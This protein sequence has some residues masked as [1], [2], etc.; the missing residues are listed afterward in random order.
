MKLTVFFACCSLLALSNYA[1]AQCKKSVFLEVA[2][3]G[4]L[5]SMNYEQHF[6]KKTNVDLMWRVGLSLA[7]IDK[8]NGTGIV[9]P[10]MVNGLVGKNAHK[11]EVGLGQGVTITT[12]GSFFALITAALGY[13]YQSDAKHWFYRIS[14]T[15]LI[16]YWVDFQ[17]QHWAGVSIGYSFNRSSP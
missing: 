7:P 16:S 15:P 8:N 14:Y 10:M 1:V 3:S 2:G 11:F 5:G 12:R 4:G 9:F 13:R 6:F 17:F